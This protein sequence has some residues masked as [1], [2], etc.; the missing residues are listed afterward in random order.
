L[1]V[2]LPGL[3]GGAK[4]FERHGFVQAVRERGLEVDIVVPHAGYSYYYARNLVE[5]LKT[6]VI[7][8]ARA[9]GYDE[10]WLVGLS[11]G[12]LGA[13]LYV[14]E[15]S[16]DITGV[17]LLSP[18]MG[19]NSIVAE[20]EKAGGIRRWDPGTYDPDKE[21]QRLFWHWLKQYDERCGELPPVYLAYG[22]D[23]GFARAHKLLA[24]VL[25]PDR[26]R[27][28]EG[29]HTLST[30]KTLWGQVLDSRVFPRK[31]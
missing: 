2:F 1:L 27:V 19:R 18:F 26:V 24:A 30:F 28:A 17:V 3:G 4:L 23:D 12:G 31:P 21:W 6:D 9:R 7:D 20:V 15:H 29:G 13:M 14:R 5:R 16:A 8:P 25:P 10:I 11:M 22:R